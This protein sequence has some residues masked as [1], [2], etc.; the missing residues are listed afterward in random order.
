MNEL[1]S[2]S[3]YFGVMICVASY[4]LGTALKKKFG[5]AIFNPLLVSI[6]CVMLFLIVFHVSYDSFNRSAK[7]LSYLLT[8]AT[9]C[10]AV[11]LYKQLSVLKKNLAAVLIGLASGVAASLLSVF[12]MSKL[13]GFTQQMYI[14]LLPKSVTTAIGMDV[15]SEL[16]GDGGIAAAVI[17]VTGLFGNMCAS[18]LCKLLRITHPVAAGLAIGCSSHAMGTA[19]ALEMGEVEGAMSSLA[20][21]VAGLMTVIG[22][23]IAA[24]LVV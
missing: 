13:F 23:P 17:I 8:P 6:V 2:Q 16:G 3:A 14:T 19:R 15:A 11:P 24:G 21:A 12:L 10:L 1:I 5:L 7:Y 20:V 9:V 18:G 22:A 4:A